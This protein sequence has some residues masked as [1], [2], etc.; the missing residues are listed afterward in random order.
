VNTAACRLRAALAAPHRTIAALVY[1]PVSARVAE[2]RGLDI[3]YL[4]GSVVKS[5]NFALPDDV[6]MS[7]WSELAEAC[8]RI[9][10]VADLALIMDVDDAGGTSLSI[11]RTV[12]ELEAAGVAGVEIEDNSV[13]QYYGQATSR[14]ALIAPVEIQ[15]DRYRAALAARR[16]EDTVVFARTV[17]H[18]FS[19]TPAEEYRRR[20]AAYAATGVDGLVLP[21]L[22]HHGLDGKADVEAAHEAAR[23]L[24]IIALGLSFELQQDSEWLA[25]N[26]VKI[27]VA[28]DNWA[29]RMA[30]R[31]IDDCFAHLAAGGNPAD[32]VERAVPLPTVRRVMTRTQEYRNWSE[33]YDSR[34]ARP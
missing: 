2:M 34:Q 29:Y 4:G 7:G 27:L 31:A 8:R 9:R 12:R 19:D 21:E 22:D 10:R 6:A 25:A 23:D 24:P 33:R 5:A 26:R 1:D 13:P 32:L 20:V 14:H 11:L 18:T 16:S 28:K 3:C 15:V 17:A 30:V